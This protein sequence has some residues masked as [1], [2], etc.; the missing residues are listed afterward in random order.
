MSKEMLD[1]DFQPMMKMGDQT[2]VKDIGTGSDDAEERSQMRDKEDATFGF[3]DQDSD[4]EM[5]DD[6]SEVCFFN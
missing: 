1:E 3:G 5:C 6:D 2:V 4:D